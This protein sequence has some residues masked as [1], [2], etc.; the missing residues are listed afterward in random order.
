MMTNKK[1][2]LFIVNPISGTRGKKHIVDEI[3]NLVD[4]QKFDFKIL[5]TSFAGEAKGLSRMADEAGY[6]IV[7]AVGGDG[8]VNEVASGLV[9]SHAA[10]G[11]IACGSGNGLARHLKLP[12]VVSEAMQVINNCEIESLDYATVNGRPFFVTCGMGFD[13][14]ISY[15]FAEAGTRGVITY[16]EQILKEWLRYKPETYLVEDENQSEQ[17]KAFLITC[18]N[19]SEYG[20][21]AFIAPQA[22]MNDGLL[23]ITIIEPF[24]AIEAP[25]LALQ[26][27]AKTLHSGGRVKMIRSD[28]ITVRRQKPGIIHID[29]DP[30]EAENELHFKVVKGGINMIVNPNAHNERTNI[31]K[32]MAALASDLTERSQQIIEA[33][34]NLLRGWR[35]K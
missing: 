23:D 2:A 32:D 18:A 19:C 24:R 13:A 20:N 35:K 31:I 8:T 5:Q 1:R 4:T 27:F 34:A 33:P 6:D 15:K 7:V 28:K 11:I 16:V 12:L 30:I 14:Y 17:Y 9:D 22:S 29:G 10:L 21:N 26:L 25:A 3:E